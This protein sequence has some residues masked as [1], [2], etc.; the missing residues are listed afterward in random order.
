[1]LVKYLESN[2]EALATE[3]TERMQDERPEL[4]Q[5]YRDRSLG[6]SRDPSEWCKEDTV[7]HLRHLAAALD[8]DDANE[9]LEYRSWL[10]Q[11]LVPRDIPEE[12]IDAN[13]DAMAEVLTSR[14]GDEAGPAISM[15][16]VR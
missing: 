4:F 8:T 7:F 1:M 16:T 3:I 13:F 5:R 11:L 10:L 15:L 6:K 2:A 14:L 12:D 9:F